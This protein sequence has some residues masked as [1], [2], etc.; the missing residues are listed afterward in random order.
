MK[1]AISIRENDKTIYLADQTDHYNMPAGYNELSRP[2]KKAAA[3]IEENRARLEEMTMYAIIR[4][5][6]SLF[7]LRFHTYCRMD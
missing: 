3:Y 6:E 7:K 4:E 2:F 1:T 5:L